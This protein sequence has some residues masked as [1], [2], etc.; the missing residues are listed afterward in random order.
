MACD[1]YACIPNRKY[2]KF[3]SVFIRN[4]AF[5]WVHIYRYS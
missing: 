4:T 2:F 3:L 1:W 5:V